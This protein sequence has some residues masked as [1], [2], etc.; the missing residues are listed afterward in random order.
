[1]PERKQHLIGERRAEQRLGGLSFKPEQPAELE[2]ATK[3]EASRMSPP[4]R[5]VQCIKDSTP[6]HIINPAIVKPKAAAPRVLAYV[7]VK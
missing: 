4:F 7:T 2:T 5:F 6:V 3:I 1:M